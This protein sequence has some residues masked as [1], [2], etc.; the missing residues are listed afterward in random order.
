MRLPDFLGIGTQKGGTTSLHFLLGEDERIGLPQRK[1]LHYFDQAQLR[2]KDYYASLFADLEEKEIIGEITPY[3]IFHPDAPRRIKEMIPDVKLIALLR[4]PVERT[5]SQYFHAVRNGYE[6][7]NLADAI[8]AEEQRLK[9]GSQYSHQ[10]HSY[11]ARSRHEQLDRYE[12]YQKDT[13]TRNEERGIVRKYNE[14][15]EAD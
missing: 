3:Y 13:N 8:M 9:E 4:D 10:K 6:V 2:S 1:E 7:F 5:I 15:M 14:L 11:I 12:R